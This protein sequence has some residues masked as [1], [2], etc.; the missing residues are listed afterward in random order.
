MKRNYAICPP[1]RSITVLSTPRSGSNSKT[2]FVSTSNH[3]S[4]LNSQ[5]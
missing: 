4:N 3:N 5:K 1:R 2:I